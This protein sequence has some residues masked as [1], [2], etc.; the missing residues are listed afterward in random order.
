METMLCIVYTK[1]GEC[2]ENDPETMRRRK[3]EIFEIENPKIMA[4]T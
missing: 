2:F 1:A 4:T 3:N